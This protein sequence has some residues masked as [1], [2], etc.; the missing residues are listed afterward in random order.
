MGAVNIYWTLVMLATLPLTFS[1]LTAAPTTME[2]FS[3]WDEDDDSSGVQLEVT[4][5]QTRQLMT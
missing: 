1:S 4:N 2:S 5:K 3:F